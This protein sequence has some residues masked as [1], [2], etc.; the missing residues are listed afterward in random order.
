MKFGFS[1]QLLPNCNEAMPQPGTPFYEHG[2]AV[3]SGILRAI[4]ASVISA[5]VDRSQR[6]HMNSSV[7]SISNESAITITAG[8]ESRE[9]SKWAGYSIST[10]CFDKRGINSKPMFLA[11][12]KEYKI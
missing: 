9:S 11:L 5:E 10:H 7:Y 2:S 8:A 6:D 12:I 3:H 4:P 1:S